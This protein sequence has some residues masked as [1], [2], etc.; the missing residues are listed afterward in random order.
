MLAGDAVVPLATAG[1]ELGSAVNGSGNSS[2]RA[3][4]LGR[5]IADAVL[6]FLVLARV[7]SAGEH[8]SPTGKQPMA[9]NDELPG[10]SQHG[11][12]LAPPEDHTMRMK[13]DARNGPLVSQP[14]EP[15]VFQPPYETPIRAPVERQPVQS[16][17]PEFS[18]DPNAKLAESYKV[19][20]AQSLV[21]K[22]H[23]DGHSVIVNIGGEG[24]EANAINVNNET[25]QLGIPNLIL[26]HGER[27]GSLFS[28]ESVDQLVANKIQAGGI[29]PR[30]L[31]EGAARILK[32]GGEF[33]LSILGQDP[34]YMEK[35][36][37]E[38]T[39]AGFDHVQR[40]VEV[41][42]GHFLAADSLICANKP[43]K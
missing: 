21:E 7:A 8:L 16:A 1:S 22:M 17:K 4:D 28:G 26:E 34:I 25:R 36:A 42:I 29:E 31:A 43:L 6:S 35:L 5:G 24:E 3:R 19:A 40:G 14:D 30:S 41:G 11:Q 10:E 33:R 2:D 18:A 32:P 37:T 20:Q 23:S 12:R 9:V 15:Q 13:P 38:L 27:I 39:R